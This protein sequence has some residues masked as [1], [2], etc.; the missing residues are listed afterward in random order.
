MVKLSNWRNEINKL[1]TKAI[2]SSIQG[3]KYANKYR[4]LFYTHLG[5]KCKFIGIINTLACSNNMYNK[6][7]QNIIRHNHTSLQ[8]RSVYLNKITLPQYAQMPQIYRFIE[9]VCKFNEDN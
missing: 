4:V 1:I 3:F 5:G 2:P 7:I 6:I 9:N 8:F